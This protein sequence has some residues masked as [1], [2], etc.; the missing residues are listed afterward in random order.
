MHNLQ[1][2]NLKC[3]IWKCDGKH[4]FLDD[5]QVPIHYTY[6]LY[7]T[8]TCYDYVT[9]SIKNSVTH[10]YT[11]SLTERFL[12]CA[13]CTERSNIC[14]CVTERKLK[15]NCVKKRTSTGVEIRKEDFCQSSKL[16]QAC[17]KCIFFTFIEKKKW[18]RAWKNVWKIQ[19]SP[20]LYYLEKVIE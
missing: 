11:H 20:L 9:S 16:V 4:L 2:E 19:S 5:T 18:E 6:T 15:E 17:S 13:L 12:C 8:I 3:I 1:F 10:I 7:I 14:K